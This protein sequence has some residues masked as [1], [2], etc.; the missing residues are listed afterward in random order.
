MRAE[1]ERLLDAP[2]EPGA[3][4]R[5][6]RYLAGSHLID[7][8]R[9]AARALHTA[10]DAL[11]GLGPDYGARYADAIRAVTGE[12]ILRVARKVIRPEACVT[13]TIRP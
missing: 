7:E 13:A 3:L 1:L 4:E 9:S 10:L 8:Q 12:D 5:A 2:P 11:Y 6:R